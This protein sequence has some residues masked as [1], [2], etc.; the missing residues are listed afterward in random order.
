MCQ[1]SSPKYWRQENTEQTLSY[2]FWLLCPSTATSHVGFPT[3]RTGKSSHAEVHHLYLK[4][5][6]IP[7]FS[8]AGRILSLLRLCACHRN[9]VGRHVPGQVP[10]TISRPNLQSQEH[11][12]QTTGT[13]FPQPCCPLLCPAFCCVQTSQAAQG[14]HTQLTASRRA[15]SNIS[16]FPF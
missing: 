13:S 16:F 3:S 1:P 15:L 2:I 5:Q 11:Q 9:C 12:P 10:K 7:C 6:S 4:H 8:R 14:V